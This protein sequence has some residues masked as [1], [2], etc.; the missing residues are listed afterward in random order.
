MKLFPPSF[1]STLVVAV[2]VLLTTLI[3]L[4]APATGVAANS[5][6]TK[7]I[8]SWVSCSGTSDDS[9]GVAKAFAA[10]RKS[11]FTL[12]VD[13]PV[14]LKIGTDIERV[15]FIDDGTTVEFSGAG[16]FIVDNQFIPAFV[17]ANSTDITL[18]SWNVEFDASLPVDIVDSGY[19]QNGKAEKGLAGN[20]FNDVPLTAWLSANRGIAFDPKQGVNSKWS[21]STNA[22]AIFFFTGDTSNVHVTGMHV[23]VPTNV[24]DD[25][26]IPVVFSMNTNYKNNQSLKTNL[27]LT[28]KYFAMPH[29]LTFSNIVLDGTYMG[30]VGNAYEVVIQDVESN[31]YGDLQDANGKNV[32]GKNKWFA[33]P[34]LFYFSNSTAQDALLVNNNIHIT[35]VVD[36]G[37]RVG[38]ARDKGGSDSISGYALSLK[39]ACT[40]CTVDTYKST[41]PDGFLDVL[42]SVNLT[43][44]NVQAT[45]NSA[46]TNNIYPGWRFPSEPYKNVKFE[47]ITLTDIADT[48]SILP[49]GNATE[50]SNQ[51]LILSNVKVSITRWG[52]PDLPLP[53]IYGNST[54]MLDY[55]INSEKT[56]IV[57]QQTPTVQTTLQASPATFREGGSTKLTWSARDAKVCYASGDWSGAI[58][59]NG[60]RFVNFSSAKTYALTLKCENGSDTSSRT[61]QVIVTK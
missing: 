8:R 35:D 14:R 30:W 48:S 5:V 18:T 20:A 33:P 9:A 39:I 6:T 52:G 27:P 23:A 3:F 25:H 57:R 49:I 45:F 60:I 26:F 32:G 50:Q 56:Q 1:S 51:N 44:S 40:D 11:A 7:S 10:A 59:L 46:F 22:C 4:S 38:T 54:V 42:P 29:D 19:K 41:R 24:G 16:K 28:S 47:N 2:T 34:H 37:P 13:C 21:G 15:I 31:R 55:A 58:G 17:I 53:R 12:M 36:S 61:L 43:V